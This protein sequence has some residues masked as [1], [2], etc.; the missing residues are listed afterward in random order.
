MSDV[1]ALMSTA[2]VDL[3]PVVR[4]PLALE[5]T[6]KS[7][8]YPIPS[9]SCLRPSISTPDFLVLSD[10]SQISTQADLQAGLRFALGRYNGGAAPQ[11][12]YRSDQRQ[13]DRSQRLSAARSS[14][15]GLR[16]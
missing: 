8:V 16:L 12:A 10:M 7:G 6:K 15:L 9:H 3:V 14:A 1:L 11:L 4:D 2:N 5:S 13:C